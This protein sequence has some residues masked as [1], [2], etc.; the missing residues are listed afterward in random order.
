MCMTFSITVTIGTS[1]AGGVL[2]RVGA[3]ICEATGCC[4]SGCG[5]DNASVLREIK[6]V[7]FIFFKKKK[8]TSKNGGSKKPLLTLT[9]PKVSSS[10]Y[11]KRV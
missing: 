2:E 8:R 9:F 11:L 10:N 1:E 3:G 5:A 4:N 6:Q 7:K